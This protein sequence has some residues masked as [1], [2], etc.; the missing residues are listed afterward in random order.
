MSADPISSDDTTRCW[1]C[2]NTVD[3][4]RMVRLG[5]HPEARLCL[6][7]AHFAHQQALR[8]E[9]REKRGPTVFARD[10]L[11]NLRGEV[12]RRGLHQNKFIGGWLRRLGKHLP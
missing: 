1:C 12:M 4:D 8:I 10:T 3:P 9:D 7:C 11:R 6:Q 5:R 2:G